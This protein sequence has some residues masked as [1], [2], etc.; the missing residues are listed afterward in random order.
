[1]GRELAS[2]CAKVRW[3]ALPATQSFTRLVRD[4]FGSN[5]NLCFDVMGQQNIAHLEKL[6]STL[7]GMDLFIVSAGIGTV[8]KTLEWQIDKTTINTM[9]WDLQKW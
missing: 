3:S 2:L 5:S 1:M 9:C 6:V 7:N 8:S 4:G